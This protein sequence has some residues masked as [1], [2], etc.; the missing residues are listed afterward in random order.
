M[1]NKHKSLIRKY[2]HQECTKEEIE[3]VKKLMLH[4]GTQQLFDEVLSENWNGPQPAENTNLPHL[5]ER[6]QQFYK[7]LAAE[8][9][10]SL[11]KNTRE[12]VQVRK[13]KKRKYWSYAAV[14]AFVVLAAGT[15][16]I[17]QFKKTPVQEQLAVREVNN[18][19]GQRSRVVLPDSSEV[20]L[21][22]GSKLR[23][24]ERFA[25]KTREISLEGEAF[26][27]V[28]KN[29][30][31]PFIIHTG[32][33]QTRVLGTSFHI[34]AFKDFPLTVSVA[35]GKVRVDDY[36]GHVLKSLAVLLPGQ[37]VS[38]AFN[39]AMQSEVNIDEV[40]DWKDGR[41]VFHRSSLK[42]ITTTLER[43]YNVKIDYRSSS[44]SKEEISVVL[45][46]K[47]PLSKIMKILAATG[48]FKYQ[49]NSNHVRIN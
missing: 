17:L 22:A 31:K 44:K 1:E 10:N 19:L 48:H 43:W 26:F 16:G 37:K 25:A 5:N 11:E 47:E 32:T 12:Q 20:F 49:I 34:E 36:A 9:E 38:Y 29:P 2:I 45:Q 8:E 35:T 7:K 6:L 15:Y 23:F 14:W 4:A 39:K 27:Q 42:E 41:L 28:T 24:P 33:V 40:K 3:E 13:L 30:D 18:P 21:G 46:G